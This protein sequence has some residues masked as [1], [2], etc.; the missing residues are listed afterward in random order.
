MSDRVKQNSTIAL[1]LLALTLLAALGG[2]VAFSTDG[3]K[4]NAA[5]IRDIDK[6][7]NAQEGDAKVAREQLA[8]IRASITDIKTGQDRLYARLDAYFS[9]TADLKSDIQRLGGQVDA[10]DRRI[11]RLEKMADRADPKPLS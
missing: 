9:Q 4:A 11:D 3:E 7:V 6:R 8:G 10:N 2:R 1:L 5:A